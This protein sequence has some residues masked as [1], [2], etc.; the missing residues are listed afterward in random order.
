VELRSGASGGEG[1]VALGASSGG[2]GVVANGSASVTYEAA[3]SKGD[4][5][6]RDGVVTCEAAR[7][8]LRRSD[9]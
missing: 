8:D 7:V 9:G 4:Q 3:R 5:R 1:V 6:R 2:D